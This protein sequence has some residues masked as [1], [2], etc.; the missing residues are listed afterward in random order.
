MADETTATRSTSTADAKAKADSER[1]KKEVDH[2]KEINKHLDAARE[3]MVKSGMPI[4]QADAMLNS[5]RP[6]GGGGLVGNFADL[7]RMG[8]IQ[9][10]GVIETPIGQEDIETSDIEDA[11]V[12]DP[13]GNAVA[14]DDRL[15]F[16]HKLDKD[17]PQP[18]PTEAQAK[19]L[20]ASAAQ[21]AAAEK[22][23]KK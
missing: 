22:E 5:A 16:A 11:F 2:N 23:D 10:A 20:K 21:A 6:R 7:Q 1:A 12:E 9:A 15:A 4:D 17:A 14:P 3:A 8:K 18:E 13:K 19:E